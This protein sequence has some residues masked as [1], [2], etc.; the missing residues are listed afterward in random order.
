MLRPGA[1][2]VEIGRDPVSS[3]SARSSH[4]RLES[5][6]ICGGIVPV[7]LFEFNALQKKVH[8]IIS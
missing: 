8:I 1:V 6:P 5:R 2:P 7:N 4:R 3:L